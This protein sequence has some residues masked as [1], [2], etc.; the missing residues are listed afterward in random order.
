MSGLETLAAIASIGGTAI[1]AIGQI[2]AGVNAQKAANY[3]ATV[4][5]NQA[6]QTVLNSNTEATLRKRQLMKERSSAIAAYGASGVQINSGSPMAVLS[7]LAS[8]AELDAAL[9]RYQGEQEAKGL[10][11]QAFMERQQGKIAKRNAITGA[12]GTLLS[13]AS[14]FAGKFGGSGG[15]AA[16]GLGPSPMKATTRLSGGGTIRWNG[17]Y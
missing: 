10:N 8:E 15:Q 2:Q 3:N 4:L 12:F 6:K 11:S 1:S 14:S 7:D 9:T 16:S 13:G 5:E 17:G